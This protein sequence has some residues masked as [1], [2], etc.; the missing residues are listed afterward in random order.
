MRILVLSM[1]ALVA[2]NPCDP[3]DLPVGDATA[4]VNGEDWE[5]SGATWRWA[6][7]SL[8]I[9]MPES[10]GW[11]F[12]LVAMR[13]LEGETV[14]DAM[15]AA[16]FP[17]EVTLGDGDSGFATVYPAEGSSMTTS[18][19]TGLLEIR[20]IEGD[21]IFACFEFPAMSSTNSVEV[22]KGE[23]HATLFEFEED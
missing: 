15:D 2:C 20:G 13:E 4:T 17:V 9:G 5:S 11:A 8:Q 16:A 14:S 21:S 3:T 22:Q 23:V 10:S 6:G 19:P 1:I 18:D 12:T 7:S